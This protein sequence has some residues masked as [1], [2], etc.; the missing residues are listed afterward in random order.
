MAVFQAGWAQA[1]TPAPQGRGVGLWPAQMSQL[2]IPWPQ[3]TAGVVSQAPH[4]IQPPRAGLPPALP[5]LVQGG[6]FSRL[7]S[8]LCHSV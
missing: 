4:G 3:A 6:E 7:A 2:Q 8:Y 5:L 1:R